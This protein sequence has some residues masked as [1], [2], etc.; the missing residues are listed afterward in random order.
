MQLT[1]PIHDCFYFLTFMSLLLSRQEP[2]LE[3]IFHNFSNFVQEKAESARS[4]QE[5][6]VG[7]HR[8]QA[9]HQHSFLLYKSP[10]Q[11]RGSN[12]SLRN[13][14]QAWLLAQT[15]LSQDLSW[16]SRTFH[17]WGLEL[18]FHPQRFPFWIYL[19]RGSFSGQSNHQM[20][21]CREPSFRL[22]MFAQRPGKWK[23]NV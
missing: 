17:F 14:R 20:S 19:D 12:F 13:S 7:T 9:A 6:G 4:D 3:L 10:F 18:R 23:P 8:Q 15:N 16:F 2:S 21:F 22:F 1:G 5:G 11:N